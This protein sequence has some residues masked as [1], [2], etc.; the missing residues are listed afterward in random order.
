MTHTNH[1]SVYKLYIYSCTGRIL[2]EYEQFC[3]Y[4]S[5]SSRYLYVGTYCLGNPIGRHC[6]LRRRCAAAAAALSSL[7]RTERQAKLSQDDTGKG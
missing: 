3:T 6:A 7:R 5:C 1:T 2:F 4:Y